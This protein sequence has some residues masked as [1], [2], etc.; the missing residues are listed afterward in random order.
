MIK[1]WMLIILIA[2]ITLAAGLYLVYRMFFSIN[3]RSVKVFEF[4][5]NPLNHQELILPAK[6]RCG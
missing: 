2:V 5:R 3:E 4:L 6:A 1:K